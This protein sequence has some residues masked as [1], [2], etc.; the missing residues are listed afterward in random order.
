[1]TLA[2]RCEKTSSAANNLGVKSGFPSVFWVSI[3][4]QREEQTDGAAAVNVKRLISSWQAAASCTDHK[5]KAGGLVFKPEQQLNRA[6][7]L[8]GK[9][10]IRI[11]N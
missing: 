11:R 6:A 8:I 10:P 5:C 1:M 3:R 4:Y 9:V 7:P 2:H